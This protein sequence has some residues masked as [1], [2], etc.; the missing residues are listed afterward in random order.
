MSLASPLPTFAV[1]TTGDIATTVG[2]AAV[3]HNTDNRRWRVVV[4]VTSGLPWCAGA[5][6]PLISLSLREGSGRIVPANKAASNNGFVLRLKAPTPTI[7]NAIV[8][9][10]SQTTRHAL[11]YT[12]TFPAAVAGFQQ[13]LGVQAGGMDVATQVTQGAVSAQAFKWSWQATLTSN[14]S[15]ARVV[16]SLS[17][18]DGSAGTASYAVNYAPARATIAALSQTP[19]R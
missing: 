4:S 1:T 15:A 11:T 18:C 5:T 7:T 12:L 8:P 13:Y 14:Y 19:S 2:A 16:A 17:T 9:R 10:D 3:M 6:P